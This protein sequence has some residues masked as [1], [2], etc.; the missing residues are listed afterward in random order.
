[1]TKIRKKLRFRFG[2]D[3]YVR[4]MPRRCS[5][6]GRRPIHFLHIGKNAGNQFKILADQI[7]VNQRS[8]WIVKHRH[9]VGLADLPKPE[10]YVFS[11]RSP[12]S[13]FRSAFYS[14]KRFGKPKFNVPWSKDET[15]S[16]ERFEHAN[17]LAEALFTEGQSGLD[18]AAAM[19]SIKHVSSPQFSWFSAKG[20]FLTTRPPTGILRTEHFEADMRSWMARNR[21][22][23]PIEFETKSDTAHVFDYSNIPVISAEGC[24]KLERWYAADMELYRMCEAW[25]L[26]NQADG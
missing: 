15:P 13:R 4:K 16:F 20:N 2:R 14:R 18:A 21:I 24:A 5:L 17:D 1:M 7:N 22:D 3:P 26:A 10:G 19:M 6:E 12:V 25:I 8:V 11:I 9:G 23:C